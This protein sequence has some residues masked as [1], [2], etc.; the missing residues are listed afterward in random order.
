MTDAEAIA[1]AAYKLAHHL[2]AL[3]HAKHEHTAPPEVKTRNQIKGLGPQTP[4]N[5]KAIDTDYVIW[6]ELRSWTHQFNTT[7]QDPTKPP[8]TAATPDHAR[9]IALNAGPIAQ[10]PDADTF[11]EELQRWTVTVLNIT[12]SEAPA[13]PEPWQL[14]PAIIQTVNRL[15]GTIT[16][17]QLSDMAKHGYI[18]SAK[19]MTKHGERNIYRISEVLAH[20]QKHSTRSPWVL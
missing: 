13:R 10:D 18:N 3:E 12:H 11:L 9:W 14:A 8:N 17:R 5:T 19:R 15:G 7:I 1:R 4:G 20:L 2:D 16:R 6:Q